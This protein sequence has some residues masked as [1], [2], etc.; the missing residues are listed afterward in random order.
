M[1]SGAPRP[2]FA[3]YIVTGC[4]ASSPVMPHPVLIRR[5]RLTA[6]TV[7]STPRVP[8]V[9]VVEPKVEG[10]VVKR[11]RKR[12]D[13]DTDDGEHIEPRAVPPSE[14]EGDDQ[15][16]HGDAPAGPREDVLPGEVQL[17]LHD[18]L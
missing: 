14:F 10:D 5:Q 13:A 17:A 2:K 7:N 11:L 4:T 12:G 6:R 3:A 8:V 15:H 16:R 18:H 1:I 9:D